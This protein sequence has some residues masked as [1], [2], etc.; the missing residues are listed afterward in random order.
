LF[1]AYIHII[2]KKERNGKWKVK[3]LDYYESDAPDTNNTDFRTKP[4]I[5]GVGETFDDACA[6]AFQN[7]MKTPSCRPYV[8]YAIRFAG[9]HRR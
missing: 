5:D 1:S 3:G 6:V 8:A 4:L 7:F 2:E 9:T